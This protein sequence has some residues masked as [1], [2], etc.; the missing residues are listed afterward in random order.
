MKIL[1]LS[2]WGIEE[3]IT[4]GTLFPLIELLGRNRTI[5]T[6]YF[7]TVEVSNVKKAEFRETHII[8]IP[9]RCSSSTTACKIW[10]VI[11]LPLILRR[12]IKEHAIH[13]LW[14]KGAP[15]GGIG[16]LVNLLTGVPFV[17]DSFEP[18]SEYMVQSGTWLRSSPKYF[19][20]R[21]M[22]TF[23]MRRALALL[24]VSSRYLNVLLQKGVSEKDLFLC[25]CV[26]D[27]S[28]FAF[29]REVRALTRKQLRIDES[30]IV[31]IYVGKYGG[32]YCDDEAF[33]LY[34]RLFAFFGPA[35]FLILLTEA[36]QNLM[37][38]KFEKYQLPR[39][40][41]FLSRVSHDLVRN[42][43]A[44]SDF[45]I[46][47]IKCAPAMQYCSPIKHGEYWAADLPILSTLD[48]GDDAEVIKNERGGIVIRVSDEQLEDKL[49]VLKG[50]LH[51]RGIGQYSKL[52]EKH[53][54]PM[55]LHRAAEFVLE[56]S[57]TLGSQSD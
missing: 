18:H 31:G 3:G 29:S 17:V 25:P 41:I 8:H 14:C 38:S 42:F 13:L 50:M 36:D 55:I 16:S 10:N 51:P 5:K 53:R 57:V 30:A 34:Q 12:I 47:T 28:K 44:A 26:V 43:L 40:R 52:A 32:L 45:A 22:E 2:S 56:K 23:T 39:Q 35:F 6:I 20:Q 48:V 21:W 4:Q 27:L 19:L 7:C 9:L 15:A 54:N 1:L 24:P 37:E 46:S 33:R 49:S 11:R